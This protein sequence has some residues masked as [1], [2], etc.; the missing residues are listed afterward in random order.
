[1]GRKVLWFFICIIIRKV[2]RG[3]TESTRSDKYIVPITAFPI[4][5][6]ICRRVSSIS[7]LL[8]NPSI[9]QKASANLCRQCLLGS[10]MALIGTVEYLSSMLA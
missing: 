2:E 1:M 8:D 6:K 3:N 9:H 4:F 5:D 10:L 7:N